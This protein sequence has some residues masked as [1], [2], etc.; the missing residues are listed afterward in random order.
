MR[1]F[2]Y[3]LLGAALLDASMYEG[4]EADRTVLAQAAA[5]VVLS[6]LATGIGATGWSEGGVPT[7]I[8]VSAIA[9]VTWIAWAVLILQ[10]GGRL[11]PESETRVDL[12]ELLR[13]TGFAAAPGLLQVFELIRPMALP[14]F[15]VTTAWMFVAMV[16]AVRHA[17]DYR[18]SWRAVAV[19]ALGAGLWLA[20]AFGVSLLYPQPAS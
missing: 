14:V 13:T 15:V 11:M 4:L 19:C 3:R 16:I 8:A 18:S 17:L 10:I 9:L 12:G 2:P 20:L 6:S 7:L 1:L 5:T